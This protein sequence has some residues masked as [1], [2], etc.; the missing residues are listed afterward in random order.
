M[1]QTRQEKKALH[2]GKIMRERLK[3]DLLETFRD[4]P[5]DKN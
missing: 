1:L 4:M 2:K 5:E 3:Y